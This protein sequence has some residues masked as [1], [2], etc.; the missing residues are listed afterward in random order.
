MVKQKQYEELTF[1]DDFMFCKIMTTDLSI[2]KD[3]LEL[4]LDIKIREIGLHESQKNIQL[5]ADS[6][7]VRF[8]VYVDDENGTVYDI[9]MQT[10]NKSDLAKRSRYYQGMIDLNLIEKGSLYNELKKSYV[11]FIC[12]SKPFGKEVPDLPIY[13]FQNICLENR[14]IVL[15]DETV[16]VFMNVSSSSPY[17]SE[18]LKLFFN[19]LK[20]YP[21]TDDLCR[22]IDASVKSAIDHDQWRNYYMTLFMRER[23]I[24]AEAQQAGHEEGL[25]EGLKEGRI[26]GESKLSRL[27]LIL[28]K[29]G[30]IED[31]TR[32]ASDEE[33]RKALYKEFNI[34]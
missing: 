32:V 22:R 15:N 20:G 18:K 12:M 9:E 26:E 13:T 8:D 1:T 16:K 28:S 5:T 10:V 6:K 23:E 17:I 31:I 4:I 25:K 21:P 19:Y 14:E 34:D 29:D 33:Y 11:I 27:V 3:V 24:F 2:C 7:G 30:R